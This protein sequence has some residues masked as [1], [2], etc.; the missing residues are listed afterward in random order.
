MRGLPFWREAI[1]VF[2]PHPLWA[3]V[4]HAGHADM[5]FFSVASDRALDAG[6]LAGRLGRLAH[7][8]PVW[9]RFDARAMT[10][11][12]YVIDVSY[13][14]G[15]LLVTSLNLEGGLG[16]QPEGFAANPMGAWLLGSLLKELTSPLLEATAP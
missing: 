5:R 3:R 1:H 12:E 10:W 6:L 14:A 8:R 11:A 13:G 9:R 15:R 2:S 4:P 16:H 7:L